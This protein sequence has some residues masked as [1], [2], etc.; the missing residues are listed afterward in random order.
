MRIGAVRVTPLALAM[1]VAFVVA[2]VLAL[3]TSGGLQTG[4]LVAAVLL[5]TMLAGGTGMGRGRAP[6][7]NRR[8]AATL[9]DWSTEGGAYDAGGSPLSDEEQS[10]LWAKE[11][12]R[13]AARG[14]KTPFGD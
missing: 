14:Q 6:R 12:E 13:R 3:L 7:W 2:V 4:A 1:M 11:R 10:A 8:A 9:G 5:A